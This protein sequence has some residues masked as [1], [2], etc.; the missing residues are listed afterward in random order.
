MDDAGDTQMLT[1][2][3]PR[4]C[5]AVKE[6]RQGFQGIFKDIEEIDHTRGIT[7]EDTTGTWT[8]Q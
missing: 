4:P 3:T 5:E 8:I 6:I 1:L 7:I 2:V